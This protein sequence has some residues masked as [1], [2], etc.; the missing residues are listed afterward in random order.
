MVRCGCFA[1]HDQVRSVTAGVPPPI[2]QVRDVKAREGIFPSLFCKG[3]IDMTICFDNFGFYNIEI[4]YLKYL[5]DID[6][7]VQFDADKVYDRKPFLGILVVIG[8]Y[9]YFLPL[10]SSKPKHSKWK[11]V[12]T[13]HYLIYEQVDKT[14]LTRRDIFKS[15]SPTEALKLFAALDIKKMIPVPE[16]LYSRVDFA[17]LTDTKYRDLLEKEYRFCQKIQNGIL[18]KASQIYKDQKESGVVHKLYCNFT[19][20]EKASKEYKQ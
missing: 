8:E 2:P 16:G 3:Y 14:E 10:T 11:N 5:H 4:D 7:E 1:T 9:N 17:A 18:S 12:G 6:P 15:I 20:L 19:L 13:A